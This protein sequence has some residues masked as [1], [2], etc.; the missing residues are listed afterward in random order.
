MAE[1]DIITKFTVDETT[2]VHHVPTDKEVELI[3]DD[4]RVQVF[5]KPPPDG[6]THNTFVLQFNHDEMLLSCERLSFV[7]MDEAYLVVKRTNATACKNTSPQP[8]REFLETIAL[9]TGVDSNNVGHTVQMKNRRCS[10]SRHGSNN[11]NDSEDTEEDVSFEKGKEED[12]D[13][14]D[15]GEASDGE[16]SEDETDDCNECKFDDEDDEDDDDD[17]GGSVEHSTADLQ[18]CSEEDTEYEED[19]ESDDFEQEEEDESV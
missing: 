16:C 3:F 19:S 15:C 4:G 1:G 13:E 14:E 10:S 8:D 17:K 2:Q 9:V 11:S 5:T 18:D 6:S 7:C 12:D